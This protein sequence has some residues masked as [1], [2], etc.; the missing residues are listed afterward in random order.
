M[1][2]GYLVVNEVLGVFSILSRNK[3]WD[4][5]DLER[6]SRLEGYEGLGNIVALV[7]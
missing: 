6:H 7:K 2:G 4:I 1:E 3:E 5:M